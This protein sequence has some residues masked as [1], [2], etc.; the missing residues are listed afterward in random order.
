MKKNYEAVPQ[1][2]FYT[3]LILVTGLSIFSCEGFGKQLQLP[4]LGV[5]LAMALALLF[6]LPI[7]VI[8]ATTNQVNNRL[9]LIS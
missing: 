5:L 4:Y 7:G 2:W 6:T 9:K 1:W 8:I 3:L